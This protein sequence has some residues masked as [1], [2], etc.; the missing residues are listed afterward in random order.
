[1]YIDWRIV[2][3]DQPTDVA[4]GDVDPQNQSEN[5]IEVISF[6]I[7]NLKCTVKWKIMD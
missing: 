7:L 3:Q 4:S 2:E 5:A 6:Y 1:M